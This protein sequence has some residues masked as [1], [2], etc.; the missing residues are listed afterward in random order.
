MHRISDPR[1]GGVSRKNLR[2]FHSICGEGSLKNVRIVTTNWSRVSEQEGSDRETDLKHG[3]FKALVDAGAQM[4]RHANTLDSARHI[5]L[6]LI[7]L[8][9]VTM[10]VQKELHDGKKLADTAAGRVICEELVE[11]Q[12]KHVQDM[13]DLKKGLELA[14]KA[15]D[16]ILKAK[17]E[18]ERKAVESSIA[19]AD[20]DRAQL[21][22]TL[23]EQRRAR[24][25]KEEEDRANIRRVTEQ[26]AQQRR[27]EQARMNRANEIQRQLREDAHRKQLELQ[28]Q[29][30]ETNR[31]VA[32]LQASHND[33]GCVIS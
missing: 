5:M 2:M 22:R 1:V 20:A 15:N 26:L 10:Q 23:E 33:G 6:E 16:R 17:A 8:Q 19:R 11:M 31:R 14:A 9:A 28:R 24:E 7:P 21:A 32:E 3:A 12:K 30:A 4:R 29:I 25:A 18:Q 27:E 13:G